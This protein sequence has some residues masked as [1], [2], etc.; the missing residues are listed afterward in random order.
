MVKKVQFI[1]CKHTHG[2]L[3]REN[4]VKSQ[5]PLGI[6]ILASYIKHVFP[7]L[8]V[9]AYDGKFYSD[10]EL[11][12][13]LDGDYIGFSTWFSNYEN[14]IE[15]AD[16][17][18]R[19]KPG[20]KIIFGGPHATAIPQRILKNN[21]CVDYVICG[22]GEISFAK[23]LSD[24][25]ETQV[26]GLV[27]RGEQGIE[28]SCSQETIPLDLLP[29]ID[30]SL[31]HPTYQWLGNKSSPAM[32]AFP[33][34]GIRGCLR[35]KNR[36]EYCS[37]HFNGYRNVSPEKYWEQVDVLNKEHG[38][39]FFFET[40]DIFSPVYLKQLSAIEKHPDVA[41]RIYSYPGILKEDD[42]PFLRAMGVRTIYMGVESILHWNEKFKRKYSPKYS[43]ESLVTEIEMYDRIGIDVIPGF[44]LGLPGENLEI[45]DQNIA[46]VNRV[47]QLKNVHEVTVSIVLPL[48]GSQYFDWCC[49]DSKILENYERLTGSSL[50]NTDKIDYYLLCKLFIMQFT[51]IEYQQFDEKIQVLR[52][53]IGSRM[54][55][56][57]TRISS[58]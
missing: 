14:S 33:L 41:F 51:S 25:P 28:S 5:P 24:Y 44:L 10:D 30:L 50:L 16:K 27:F 8:Q 22:E 15:L 39:D 32:S 23:L 36:C 47:S 6:L 56:W 26:P 9:E 3:A 34:S 11:L 53:N 18:K 45:L 13:R 48:P 12:K 1:F 20:T 49:D 40:G 17:I 37:I 46:L 31:L 58:S 2:H 7:E 29:L 4:E 57:G 54:A 19:T 21:Q 52:G 35:G 42:L 55:N 38:I 43:V